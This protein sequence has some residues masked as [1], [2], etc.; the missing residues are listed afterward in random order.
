MP[1]TVRE[2]VPGVADALAVTVRVLVPVD[3]LD[4]GLNVAVMP[5]G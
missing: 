4:V 3:V 1:V 2:Y 5:D